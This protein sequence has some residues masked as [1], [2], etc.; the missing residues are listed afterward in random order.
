[1]PGGKIEYYYKPILENK[2][3]SL[4]DVLKKIDYNKFSV[5]ELIEELNLRLKRE[6][7]Q[8]EFSRSFKQQC[9]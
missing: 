9:I 8:N 6:V 7:Y 5:S 3:N 4:Q 1:M 2:N